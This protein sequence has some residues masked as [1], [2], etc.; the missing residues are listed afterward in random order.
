MN[1]PPSA[2]ITENFRVAQ[3]APSTPTSC[4]AA[5]DRSFA[6]HAAGRVPEHVGMHAASTADA[7]RVSLGQPQAAAMDRPNATRWGRNSR[8]WRRR[9]FAVRPSSIAQRSDSDRIR[10][11]PTPELA[12]ISRMSPVSV[13]SASVATQASTPPARKFSVIWP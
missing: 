13:P 1:A 3:S 9:P 11:D 2:K 10:V 8:L 4:M 12:P 7:R 5:P 6:S